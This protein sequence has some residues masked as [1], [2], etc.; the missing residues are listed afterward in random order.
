MGFSCKALTRLSAISGNIGKTK[1]RL[2]DSL[3]YRKL[4]LLGRREDSHVKYRLLEIKRKRKKKIF[5]K[6][7]ERRRQK[8]KLLEN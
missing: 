1:T 3:K 8:E 7:S 4:S 2:M 5:V 6:R